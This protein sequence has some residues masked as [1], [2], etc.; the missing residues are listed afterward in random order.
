MMRFP[1]HYLKKK[2]QPS[3]QK[4]GRIN[5]AEMHQRRSDVTSLPGE[6]LLLVSLFSV[7]AQFLRKKFHP[8]FPKFV[9]ERVRCS[10]TNSPNCWDTTP[11]V[12]I[13]G[14]TS[15]RANREKTN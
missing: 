1:H 5:K 9:L 7:V 11:Y 3:D 6:G 15:L 13:L 12:R 4:A 8:I 2:V 14:V 10:T